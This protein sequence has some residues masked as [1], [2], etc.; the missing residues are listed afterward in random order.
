MKRHKR[1]D[2]Q[3]QIISPERGNPFAVVNDKN[4]GL[5]ENEN[6]KDTTAS[7]KCKFKLISIKSDRCGSTR[8]TAA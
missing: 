4:D 3:G 6:N 2:T 7:S 8:P 1:Q 5:H